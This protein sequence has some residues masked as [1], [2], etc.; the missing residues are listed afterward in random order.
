[1]KGEFFI[2]VSNSKVKYEFS[3]KRNITVIQGDS[4]TGKTTLVDMIREFEQNGADSGINLS[5]KKKCRVLEGNNW[6]ENLSLMNDSIVFIDEGNRFV[7]SAD[8]AK[9]VKNSGNYYVIV[10]R[11]G[12]DNLPY[13]VEEI[14]GIHTSGKYADLKQVY[15]EFY[16][17]YGDNN[18]NDC[19]IEKIITEDS[20]SG[21]DFFNAVCGGKII[22]ESANG[23]SNIYK[24]LLQS[25][26]EKVLAVAD[27]AAFGSQMNL[28]GELLNKQEKLF[29]FAPESFEWLILQSDILNDNEV[30]K[31]LESPENYIESKD[32]F[33]WEQ[34]FTKLLVEKTSNTFLNY[35][36]K[37]INPN[38]LTEN[39]KRKILTSDA[40]K[41][42]WE[43]MSEKIGIK[44]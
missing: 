22:C 33:S 9:A 25:K 40:L 14:Y 1:M 18:F 5:S 7:E 15:H 23:K 27:G 17:I 36:K 10:T 38:Y 39:V 3:I 26:G 42:I 6:K 41:I 4:A 31:I 30:K 44:K 28:V 32:Y 43:S 13:S 37:K 19:R 29:L 20:N 8:F 34:Y 16:R 21:F 2:S 24:K 12:L 11:E 35:S